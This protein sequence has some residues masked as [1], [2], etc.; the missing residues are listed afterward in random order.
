MKK[1]F[2]YR[3]YPAWEQQKCLAKQFGSARF[4]YNNAL[5]F[6]KEVYDTE[7]K[8]SSKYD[9][10]KRLVP[11]KQEFPWLTE[12]DSQVLQQSIGNLDKAFSNFFAQRAGFPQ[13]K[14]KYSRQSIQ[15]PQRVKVDQ[16]N[17]RIYLPKLGWIKIILHRPLEGKIK[18][19]N[20][21]QT[22]TGKYYASILCD[23]EMQEP[24]L[25]Q[26]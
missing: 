23:T 12:C 26:T 25:V 3:L 8:H 17:N 9:L 16:E 22:V 10:I 13:F 18:T 5:A 21:S 11:L 4:V 14:N 6:K 1:A 7:K 20:V 2:K 15:Y 24:P 19:V